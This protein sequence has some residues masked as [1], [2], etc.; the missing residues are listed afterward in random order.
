MW[1]PYRHYLREAYKVQRYLK[2]LVLK[3]EIQTKIE[4][5]YYIKV[6]KVTLN[7]YEV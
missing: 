1:F 3:Y 5:R 6:V 4:K 7:K 2:R